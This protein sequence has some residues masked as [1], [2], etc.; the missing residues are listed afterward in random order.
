MLVIMKNPTDLPFLEEFLPNT[1]P[2]EEFV[3]Q[4]LCLVL[5]LTC[6]REA[7]GK[8]EEQVGG[9]HAVMV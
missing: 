9:D 6:G 2:L 4:P 5:R 3:D 1:H 8:D 7:E